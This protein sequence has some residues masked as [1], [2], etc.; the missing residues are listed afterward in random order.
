MTCHYPYGVAIAADGK[1]LWFTESWKHRISRAAVSGRDIAAPQT[2]IGNMPGYPARLGYCA[3]GGWLSVFA[4]RTHL[5]EFVLREDDFRQRDADHP[6]RPLDLARARHQRLLPRAD[7]VRLR[8]DSLGIEKPWAPPRSYGLLV[9]IDEDGEA[10]ESL[11]SQV[12]GRHHGITAARDTAQGLVIVSRGSGRLLL[13]RS[14][15]AV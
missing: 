2:V 9:R 13:D 14:G 11:H 7:A 12:G 15:G 4:V 3:G 5:V 6:G 10:V 8:S 1:S